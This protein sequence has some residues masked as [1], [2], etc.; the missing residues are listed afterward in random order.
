MNDLDEW[1][2][3]FFVAKSNGIILAV[4]ELRKE[5]GRSVTLLGAFYLC[6]V[7]VFVRQKVLTYIQ[8]KQLWW[9]QDGTPPQCTELSSVSLA[10]AHPS[11]KVLDF[12]S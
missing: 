6:M 5:D 4:D 8:D 10:G 9:R 12:H 11:L 2:T 1:K 3:L 7:E